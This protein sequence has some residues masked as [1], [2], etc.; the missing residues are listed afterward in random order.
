ME[1]F[2]CL[3]VLPRSGSTLLSAILSQ[4]PL[5]HSEGNSAVCQ[6]MWDM[7]QSFA[8]NAKEQ[9]AAN[10][11]E[12]TVYDIVSQIPFL[13]YKNTKEPIIID[14]CRSWTIP[15]N[16]ELLKKYISNDTKIIILQRPI[17][18][19]V[20]SMMNI[21]KKNNLQID[22]ETL[23]KPFSEP[24]MRSLYG[25]IWAKSNNT[26]NNFLFINY[27]DL[28]SKPSETIKTIYEFCGWTFFEHD[29]DNITVKYPEND[30]IYNLEGFHKVRSSISKN[31]YDITLPDSIVDMCI[32]IEN[33]IQ[34][35][36]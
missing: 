11:R 1:Q 27:S 3:S 10:N 6:L 8:K 4:N 32:D 19:I 24:I 30:A 33:Q 28:V 34:Q 22:P 26:N 15:E 2:V 12:G 16:V 23:L 25:L 18:E 35:I 29:F 36:K 17:V 14:K 13:Y 31:D 7:S 21:Y 20:K 9:I 5:I